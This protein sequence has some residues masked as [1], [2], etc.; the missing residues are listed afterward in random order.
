MKKLFIL[1][2]LAVLVF[3]QEAITKVK[4]SRKTESI[5]AS[6]F[7]KLPQRIDVFITLDSTYIVEAFYPSQK[8]VVKLTPL[9]YR[10]LLAIQHPKIITLENARV[11]YLIGQTSLGLGLYSWAIPMAL[12]LED[13]SAAVIGLFTPLLYASTHY[14]LTSGKRISSGSAFGAFMGGIEGAF[15]GGLLFNSVTGILPLSLG[16]NILDNVLG[17]TRGFTP[18]M[19][20]RKF[21]YCCYGYYHY[22]AIK[23]LI[24]DWDDW[25][26][27]KDIG[28]IGT[29]ISLGEGYTALFLSNN[30]TNLTYGDALFEFR[31]AILGAEALPLILATYDLHRDEQTNGRIYAVTSLIG[32]GLGYALGRKLTEKYD[33][34]GTAGILTWIVPYLA[35]G[36]T[37]GLMVLAESEGLWKSYPVIFLTT[38]L[39]LTYVCYKTFAEKTTK[40]GKADAHNFNIAVNPMCFMLKDKV[41][42]KMPF[43]MVSY[44]F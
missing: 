23:S 8:M 21:S 41:G 22:V 32:H 10:D 27:R 38:D 12:G 20:Q 25:D 33:L 14:F 19:Y 35:H 5:L 15:H 44:N 6:L 31:T 9:E 43:L 28:Q 40:M 26:D 37:A 18:T 13:K 4:V 24:S 16:E 2:V 39:A 36:T 11:S 30:S 17:Q 7:E 29:L 34:S 3:A 42:C 1:V